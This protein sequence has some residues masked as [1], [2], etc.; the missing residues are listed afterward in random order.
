MDKWMFLLLG[1]YLL[2]AIPVAYIVSKLNGVDLQSQGSK[3]L[4]AT[5][6]FRVMGPRWG[7]LVFA[8]DFIKGAIPSYFALQFLDD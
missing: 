4:G 3:N 1:A 2:G 5:N 7:V 6:V 8:L